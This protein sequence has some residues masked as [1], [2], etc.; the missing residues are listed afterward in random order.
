MFRKR[1]L[2]FFFLLLK[3][4]PDNLDPS[5]RRDMPPRCGCPLNAPSIVPTLAHV[6]D[7]V[8]TSSPAALLTEDPVA[9]ESS[10]LAVTD[11]ARERAVCVPM[12]RLAFM[13]Y[14]CLRADWPSIVRTLAPAEGVLLTPSPAVSPSNMP[15]VGQTVPYY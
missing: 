2:F 3:A 7:L 13:H 5:S 1:A 9:G 8:L 4:A 10:I 12:R 11:A 6:E 14:I 15:V